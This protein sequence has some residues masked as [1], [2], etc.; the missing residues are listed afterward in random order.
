[1][2]IRS[3]FIILSLLTTALGFG[4]AWIAIAAVLHHL[5]DENQGDASSL[6]VAS[7]VT[8]VTSATVH[9]IM[10]HDVDMTLYAPS[11]LLATLLLADTAFMQRR[12]AKHDGK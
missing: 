8:F 9:I 2:L 10:Q 7:F 4:V 1:V 12:E 3:L 5:G 6:G 11:S